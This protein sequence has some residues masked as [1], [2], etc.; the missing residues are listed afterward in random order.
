MIHPFAA[1]PRRSWFLLARE[2]LLVTALFTAYKI[3]RVLTG[4]HLDTAYGNA[5]HVWGLERSMKLPDETV[6]QDVLLRSGTLVRAA[7]LFYAGVHFT[8][9]AA[10][11][12]WMFWRRRDHYLWIRRVL[13]VLTTGALLVEILVPLAPPRMLSGDG[14]ID[15]ARL[16]GP[17]VYGPPSS[18]RLANQ[19]AAMPSLH[20]GWALLVAV[21]LI[22]ATKSRWRWLWL[23][24]PIV[25][26]A[27]VVG[28]ANHYWVDGIVAVLL[29]GLAL[30]IVPPPP[31]GTTTVTVPL[32]TR[33]QLG[34]A[35]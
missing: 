4:H 16:Y 14:L 18:D 35:A 22:T 1:R 23:L 34:Q 21:G 28:T 9:T 27:V 26:V 10:F 2:F 12:L 7:N 15:T 32:P 6:V 13:V 19:F 3:G 29:L 24:H 20:V 30:R 25:T 8:A 11:L 17:S 33:E 31:R 5:R